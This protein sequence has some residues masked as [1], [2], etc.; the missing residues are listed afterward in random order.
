MTDRRDDWDWWWGTWKNRI[1]CG[2]C[3]A[4]MDADSPCPVCAADYSE[5]E[6][7]IVDGEIVSYQRILPGAL[8]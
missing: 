3:Q 1:R 5:P 2:A 4:L 8:D 7:V 6:P